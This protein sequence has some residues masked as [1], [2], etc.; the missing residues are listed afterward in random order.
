MTR[1]EYID[2]KQACDSL[3]DITD[4]VVTEHDLMRCVRCPF[5]E[6]TVDAKLTDTTIECPACNTVVK[7]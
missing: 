3:C 1:Q 5:C 6:Q 7:R 4:E 2:Q